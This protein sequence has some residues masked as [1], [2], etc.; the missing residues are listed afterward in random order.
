MT[1]L[2]KRIEDDVELDTAEVLAV[3]KQYARSKGHNGVENGETFNP[4]AHVVDEEGTVIYVPTFPKQAVL[5]IAM[6]GQ[7]LYPSST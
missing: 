4:I 5:A 1:Y 6:M 3:A 7:K 2:I